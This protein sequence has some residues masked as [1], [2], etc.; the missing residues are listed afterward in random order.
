M[1][2]GA[3]IEGISG[4]FRGGRLV[5]LHAKR[6]AQRD[7]FADFLF[8]IKDADRLGEVALVDSTSRIGKA[9]RIYYNTLLD[10]NAAAHMAFGT[11][12]AHTRS[13]HE[14]SRSARGVNRSDAHVD[15]MIGSEDLEATG[16]AAKG[17]R[18]PLIAAG[19]WQI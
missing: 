8:A 4:E 19:I 10:E 14:T 11:G 16:V 9:G 13:N 3:L 18:V 17:R 15:V 6:K 7:F 2:Q 12:F 5:R 1:F